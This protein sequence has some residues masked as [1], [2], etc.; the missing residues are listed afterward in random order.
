MLAS[1]SD[2]SNAVR[3]GVAA[4]VEP[5]W[6][7]GVTSAANNHRVWIEDSGPVDDL[8]DGEQRMR[9]TK[10]V[11]AGKWLPVDPQPHETGEA[12]A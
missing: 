4:P 8:E 2:E 10:C 1:G 9:R 11:P 5:E 3:G 6:E 7:Y 12:T